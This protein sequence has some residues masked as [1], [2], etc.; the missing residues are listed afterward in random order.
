MQQYPSINGINRLT[1]DSQPCIAFHKYDG[2][3]IRAQW[4]RKSNSWR[5]GTRNVLLDRSTP[6]FGEAI[7]LFERTW[8]EPLARTMTDNKDYRGVLQ[9]T[10]FLEYH[11]PNSFAGRHVD[12]DLTLTLIDVDIYKRGMIPPREFINNFGH[13]PIAPVVYEGDLNQ[14]FI[15]EVRNGAYGQNEGVVCK[16]I[17][18][19]HL[20]WRVKIKTNWWLDEL[21]RRANTGD[22]YFRRELADNL[23]EQGLL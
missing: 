18:K 16:G 6:I 19:K 21:K 14:E 22:E 1:P 12:E 10:F 9:S 7:P 8:A 15:N 17:R 2:N 20:I 23:R 13:L 4:V 3:N 5:Y 11:G